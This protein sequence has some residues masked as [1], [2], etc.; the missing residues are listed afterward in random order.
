MRHD[1]RGIGVLTVLFVMAVVS[2]LTVTAAVVTIDNLDNS[3]RDRQAL[4]ALATSEAGVTHAIA[5]LR[6][7]SLGA[8]TCIEPAPGQL[9]GPTCQ[10]PT[11]SWS[12]ATNPMQVRLDGTTGSCIA[13]SDCFKVW[14]GTV[15]FYEAGCSGRSAT[16]P[17]PCTG[18]YRVHSTGVS[19][20][21]P[22]AR[23]VAVDV[24]V[25]PY[26]FPIGIFAENFSGNG[27][28][29][30]HRQSLFTN[31]CVV[32]RQRD[33]KSGSGFQFEWDSA[34]SRPK[35][36]IIYDQPS[37]AH[38]TSDI[39][40]SNTSC[41]GGGGGGPIHS[42]AAPCNPVFAWDQ[43]GTHVSGS[44]DIA[45]GDLCYG[46][47]AR[48]NG[49]TYPTSSKFTSED[50]QRYGYVPRGLTDAQYDALRSQAQSQ[51]TYNLADGNV[52]GALATALAAGVT[53]PVLYWDSR[54]VAL[55]STSFPSDFLRTLNT[56]AS[57]ISN[58]VTIVV[59]GPGNN[60]SYQGGNTSP[61]LV[62]SMFVPDGTLTGNGGRNTIGTVYA[63]VL[64]LGGNA[65]F[66]MDEC[67]A[68]NPPGGT[69]DVEVLSFREDDG[70]DIN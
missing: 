45:S 19:G 69:L 65:D 60:L 31:G 18:I 22:G 8:L 42:P 30:I 44:N 7:G 61:Y 35:L 67:F 4:A 59:A 36:D 5:R 41:T 43:S 3:R 28:V 24:E 40:T 14:I 11:Q 56:S 25:Q 57:C 15:Q 37:A 47:Y 13:Q 2:A 20:N 62:A 27:N 70:T 68:N 26:P 29:G 32:N 6:T 48:S 34:N 51:G 58:S 9:P 54:S 10:G 50:L 33:D 1:D 38:S 53:S 16:P 66:Y 17:R 55:N 21:G 23:R 63:K 64:D 52:N 12:S 39:S 46:K 49:T